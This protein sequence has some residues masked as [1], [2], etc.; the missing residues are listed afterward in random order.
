[1]Y[2]VFVQW[3]GINRSTKLTYTKARTN[4]ATALDEVSHI[5]GVVIIK[6]KNSENVALVS[7]SESVGIL[8]S[9]HLLHSHNNVQRFLK[10]QEELHKNIVLFILHVMIKL[11]LSNI[12]IIIKSALNYYS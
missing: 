12:G 4:L 1:M 11:I 6:R 2:T 5:T 3:K 10:V 8:E 7:E 9:A